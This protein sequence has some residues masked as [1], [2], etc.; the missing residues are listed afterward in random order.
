MLHTY[1]PFDTSVLHPQPLLQR[2]LKPLEHPVIP[3]RRHQETETQFFYNNAI[4]LYYKVLA[5]TRVQSNTERR[6][7]TTLLLDRF[8][9]KRELPITCLL[10]DGAVIA[11]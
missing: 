6:S 7:V 8:N 2:I 10:F 5:D 1:P 4:D 3:D 9:K 11:L